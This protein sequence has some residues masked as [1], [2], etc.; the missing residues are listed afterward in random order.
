MPIILLLKIVIE[1]ALLVVET[2]SLCQRLR[3]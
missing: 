3:S 1:A 2:V